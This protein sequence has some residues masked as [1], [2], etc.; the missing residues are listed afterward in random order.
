MSSHGGKRH[1]S[2]RSLR[3]FPL[4]CFFTNADAREAECLSKWQRSSKRA[5]LDQKVRWAW[6][7]LR[8]ACVYEMHLHILGVVPD[9]QTSFRLHKLY[10]FLFSILEDKFNLWPAKWRAKNYAKPNFNSFPMIWTTRSLCTQI[11][12]KTR[13]LSAQDR[14][15][16]P[17][18]W[19]DPLFLE[20][21]LWS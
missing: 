6:R 5:Y 21:N 12:F 1:G 9:S 13:P 10:L 19:L 16:G 15:K 11:K 20:M 17:H 2:G 4:G 3:I 18:L 14:K 8:A 7:C